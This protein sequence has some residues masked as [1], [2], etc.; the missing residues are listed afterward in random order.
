MQQTSLCRP[1]KSRSF[2]SK[3]SV[4]WNELLKT[5]ESG[6]K[7]AKTKKYSKNVDIC[8]LRSKGETISLALK[9]LIKSYII[10]I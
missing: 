4:E 5:T 1:K 8:I 3:V 2:D 7:V 10:N 9:P 6:L